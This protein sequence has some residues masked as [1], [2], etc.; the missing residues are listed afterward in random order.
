MKTWNPDR[1]NE[2]WCFA[3]KAH[4][5]QTYGGAT[6]GE[7]VPYLNHLGSV[8]MEVMHALHFDAQLDGNFAIQ[9]ALLHDTIEDTSVTYAA[10]AATFGINVA[11]GVLA[12]SKNPA[13]PK[14]GQMQDSLDRIC[15]QPKEVAVVKLADRISN[16]KPPPFYW[17]NQKLAAYQAESKIILEKL[18][19]ASAQLTARL[20][21]KIEAY[22]QYW[23]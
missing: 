3:T 16:L 6:E 13:L 11:N 9:C 18:G 20:Q 8:T 17:D 7:R 19:F 21:N 1:Y 5:G 22:S 12:L 4:D 14:A 2:A 15:Q 10:I 23:R